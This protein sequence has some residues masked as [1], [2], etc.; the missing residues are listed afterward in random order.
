M[1]DDD[2]NLE[3]HLKKLEEWLGLSVASS[4]AIA[5]LVEPDDQ[6]RWQSIHELLYDAYGQV[7]AELK[8]R[9]G[10]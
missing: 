7:A 6:L 5:R 8:H 2:K 3:Q 10:E 9:L 4:D 1:P